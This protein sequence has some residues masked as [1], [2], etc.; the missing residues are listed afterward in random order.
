MRADL[1]ETNLEDKREFGRGGWWDLAEVGSIRAGWS[2]KVVTS[3]MRTIWNSSS[4][5][6]L[7]S[8]NRRNQGSIGAQKW[9]ATRSGK[10]VSKQLHGTSTWG[11]NS[12]WDFFCRSR[13]ELK[14]S[15]DRLR[16]RKSTMRLRERWGIVENGWRE[17]QGLPGFESLEIAILATWESNFEWALKRDLR[18]S[19]ET[20]KR[21]E[22][23]A[24]LISCSLLHKTLHSNRMLDLSSD[25]FL[26]L[27][28]LP[29]F[30]SSFSA[31]CQGSFRQ[32]GL[33]EINVCLK[34][35]IFPFLSFPF[36]SLFL[37]WFS[38]FFFSLA[39]SF[40]IPPNSHISPKNYC[41]TVTF[42]V[43]I[44]PK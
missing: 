43:C 37:F 30:L 19:E 25:S 44:N 42:Y 13:V 9:S 34:P 3:K 27:P 24:S 33:Q 10:V 11:Q 41:S 31:H 14:L 29:H 32:E 36:S 40:A 7:P 5:G 4:H 17:D 18:T 8:S 16:S 20:L 35:W 12:Y 1:I 38:S 39:V 2:W 21:K 22:R 6:S 23:A 26:F 28:P 15:I